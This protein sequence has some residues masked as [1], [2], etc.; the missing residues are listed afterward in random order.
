[1]PV[2]P[3]LPTAAAP[4]LADPAHDRVLIE[5]A[6]GHIT[7]RIGRTGGAPGQFRGP[8]G[9]A[10][11]TDGT[12]YVADMGNARIQEFDL[13]GRLLGAS[14]AT[15]RARPPCTRRQWRAAPDGTLYVADAAQDAM[16]HFT[17][18]GSF[19]GRFGSARDGIGQFDGPGGI[20][21][22]KDGTLYVADTLNNRVQIFTAG[23]DPLGA[24]GTG[25]A[26]QRVLHWP[27]TVAVLPNGGVAIADADNARVVTVAHPLP[28]LGAVSLANVGTPG[29]VLRRT[30]RH[31]LCQRHGGRP[32]R[33]S[34]RSG[35][36][37][38]RS[39]SAVFSDGHLSNPAVW[40][41]R[42]MARSTSPIRE[43]PHRS[44]FKTDGTFVRTI[45]H[46]GNGPEQMMGPHAVL[47]DR[48]GS[49]WIADTFNARVEHYSADGHL[50]GTP[51]THANGVLGVAADNQGGVYY[52][53]KWGQRIYHIHA[54]GSHD[55]GAEQGA[56]AASS[57]TQP[58]SRWVLTARHWPRSTRITAACS[59]SAAD[60]L[61]VECRP[62]GQPE[63]VGR[64]HRRDVRA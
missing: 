24:L 19:L 38:G 17:R 49:L 9:V 57:C 37:W 59:S 42:P 11:G 47:I 31:L 40:R 30:R 39:G 22:G 25:T 64:S 62:Y 29:G 53:A 8:A 33:T 14:G 4:C 12:L 23:G 51:V 32:H 52:S 46:I 35:D 7:A 48:D 21:V 1:M 50:L 41:C 15:T 10:I 36:V 63:R 13:Q 44:A 60:R 5:D 61:S 6:A 54:N 26:G 45:S 3:W 27:S 55:V 18:M 2:W 34:R 20:A 56:A 28:Y 58:A 43:R 16:L